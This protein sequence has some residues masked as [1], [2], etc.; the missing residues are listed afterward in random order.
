M[1]TQITSDSLIPI[2]QHFRV[3][4]GPGAGKTHWLINHIKNVLHTSDRL[5]KTRKIACIT[6]TN[7]AVETI[8]KRLGNASNRVEVSTIHSFLYK[9]IV[10]PY[11]RFIADEY[12]INSKLIDGHD[13]VEIER[14]YIIEWIKNHKNVSSLKHPYSF[15]QLTKLEDNIQAIR[16][17]LSAI[18][19]KLDS[20]GSLHIYSIPSKAHSNNS[21]NRKYLSKECLTLLEKDFISLKKLYWRN[22]VL[23]H[24]DVLFLAYQLLVKFPFIS[25]VLNAKF[26][27]FYVDEFQDSNPIQIEI[28]KIIGQYET[29]LGVVGDKSQSIYSFQ[30]ADPNQFNEFDLSQIY[31]Y[32]ILDNRRSTNQIIDLLNII[33]PNFKQNGIININDELP[34][35]LV[36]NAV[37][38]L[39]KCKEICATD[40]IN[41]LTRN[42]LTSNAIKKEMGSDISTI[43]LLE[44]LFDIDSNNER[45]KVIS[46]CIKAVEFAKSKC[47]KDALKNIMQFC[48]ENKKANPEALRFLFLLVNRY[49]EYCEGNVIDFHDFV[50]KNIRILPG[51]RE[52]KIKNFYTNTPYKQLAI[53]VNIVGDRALCRTIHKSK[54]DEFN[55]VM[56]IL[57]K[58]SDLDFLFNPDLDG[59]E[60]H[61][62][63]YVAASR[64][65]RK[66]FISIPSLTDGNRTKLKDFPIGIIDLV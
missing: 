2:E 21:A 27:Y 18:K 50:S 20:S 60:E 22:G 51:F 35:I 16:N 30:G 55:N 37:S 8:L 17:W 61:R 23:A 36:G 5:Q 31:D 13:D 12:E 59:E 42:N 10:K 53:A 49:N 14:S 34:C 40:E 65:K 44:E 54:G 19:F 63:Y 4:A 32:K 64:A 28:L 66:L 26:P 38:A 46:S 3:S 39:N 45:R 41:V 43:N 52:G 58:E 33:R 7:V 56:L 9:H 6:Y 48:E 47:I 1:G 15:K 57:K 29:K 24:D 62:I 25:D 11:V